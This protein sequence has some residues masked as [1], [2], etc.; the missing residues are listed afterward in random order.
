[1]RGEIGLA[2]A[3]ADPGH[4]DDDQVI[5]MFA[6]PRQHVVQRR[7]T[8]EQYRGLAGEAVAQH[9]RRYVFFDKVLQLATHEGWIA[10]L[11]I[12]CPQDGV[13]L[14]ID[15][16]HERPI[17]AD[18][19]VDGADRFEQAYR[20]VLST[21]LEA[22]DLPVLYTLPLERSQARDAGVRAA[23]ETLTRLA[24]EFDLSRL[25]KLKETF[26]QKSSSKDDE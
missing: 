22:D 19:I 21:L 15:L 20:T 23:N 4:G 26:E 7:S 2:Q 14:L 24:V 1:M 3:S 10:E 5:L 11:D 13:E 16:R 25:E 6:D 18:K 12:V 8:T 17:A 9:L